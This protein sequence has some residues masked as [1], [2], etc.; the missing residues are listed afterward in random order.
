MAKTPRTKVAERDYIAA[1][2]SVTDDEQLATGVKYKFL[3]TGAVIERKFDT[4][5]TDGARMLA[6]FGLK[7]WIGNLMSQHDGDADAVNAKLDSVW[8]G[9]WPDREGAIGPRYDADILALAIAQAKGESDP[10][11]YVKK[12]AEM[13]G[14]GGKAYSVLE[15][16]KAYDSL[17]GKA[18]TAIGDL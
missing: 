17:A 5:N 15:V 18:S 9:K 3:S 2:G 4:I 10:A 12:I 13:K 6:L 11:P 1:D 16:R 8:A 7:T 14:Y